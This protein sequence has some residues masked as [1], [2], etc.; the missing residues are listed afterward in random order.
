MLTFDAATKMVKQSPTLNKHITKRKTDLYFPLTFSKFEPLAS[1]ARTLEGLNSHCI[2]IDE[3]HSLQ[4]RSVYDVLKRSTAAKSRTQP[5][6][7]MITTA[8]TVRES[9]YDEMYK[10]SVDVLNGIIEDESFFPLLYELDEREEWTNEAMWIKANP[11]LDVIKSI[12][13]LRREV[14]KAK[15]DNLNLSELLCK[16]FN[17]PQTQVGS[18]L[19]YEVINNTETYNLDDLRDC[20]AIGGVDLSSTTDLTAAKLL[21]MKPND[22]KKYIISQYFIPSEVMEKKI[23]EDKVPYDVWESR[24][25][26][27][28]TPGN[29][30]DYSFV[31]QWFLSMYRDKGIIPMWIGYDPW[32]S[33]YWVQEMKDTG[34]TME[35]VRQGA[36]TFSSPAKMMAGDLAD[37]LI[38]YNNNSID[39]WCL[40]NTNI[41]R[42]ENDNI[43]PVKKENQKLRIDGTLALLNCY[44]VLLNHYQDYQNMI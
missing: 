20:Y 25:L 7:F 41:K 36:Q 4:T 34:F 27:T 19:T 30:V 2:I 1:E 44:V 28:V 43:R 16:D 15:N 12:D 40:T 14:E 5:L 38:N 26:V 8:G 24:G 6:L 13:Y 10:Y 22:P 33:T 29:S 42:D 39:K 9:I 11:G 21:V 32:N 18:W 37:K 3:V 31:T 35:L 17:L 23:K